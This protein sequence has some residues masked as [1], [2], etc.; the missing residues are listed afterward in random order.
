MSKQFPVQ[1]EFQSNQHF[2]NYYP[3]DNTEV[4]KHLQ[5]I[6]S[7]QELQTYLWG[8]AGTGKTH[9]LQ[10][11]V[12]T[13][14]THGLTSF[15]LSL[16]STA[17]PDP[18]IVD[19]L[20][21]LDIVCLDNVEQISENEEW[22]Q[23]L[24]NFYNLHRDGN[25]KLI[26]SASCPPKF[27][28]IQLPDLKTRMSWGITFKL[29]PLTDEQQLQALIHKAYDLGFNIPANVGRFLMVHYARDLPTIWSMLDKIDHATLSA[30]R[31][32]TIPFLKQ[33]MN[34]QE[35]R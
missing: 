19:G 10:A 6:C 13:A 21:N 9:L 30:K 18:S 31:K 14:N 28:A 2:S 26:I 7:S 29:K 23:A 4:V 5:T 34:D 35:E 25:K 22:E 24:F 20:E 33:I 16:D 15:Y 11:T 17:L 32:L 8:E 12:Q 27:L 3:G 1:F